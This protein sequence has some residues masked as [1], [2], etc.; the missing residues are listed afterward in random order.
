[1]IDHY[2][3]EYITASEFT[4]VQAETIT[5]YVMFVFINFIHFT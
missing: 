4:T 3:K 2:M 5:F 1:M